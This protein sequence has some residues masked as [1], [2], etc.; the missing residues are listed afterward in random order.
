MYIEDSY[1]EFVKTYKNYITDTATVMIRYILNPILC[2]IFEKHS[3]D[4]A[5]LRNS[6]LQRIGL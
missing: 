4:F 1:A 6:K 5:L 3:L 2:L